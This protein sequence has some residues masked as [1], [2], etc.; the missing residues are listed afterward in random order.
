MGVIIWQQKYYFY[1]FGVEYIPQEVLSKIKDKSITQKF[2]RTQDNESLMCGFYCI[3]FIKYMLAGKT[4]LDY[5]NFFLRMTIKIMT[6]LYICFLKT[7]V[8]EEASLELR[9][10]K[11]DETRN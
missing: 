3:A 5:T 4:L 7:N 10:R 11:I 2:F 1:Y 6:K 8:V 9:L